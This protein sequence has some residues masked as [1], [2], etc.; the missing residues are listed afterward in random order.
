MSTPDASS[1]ESKSGTAPI[2]WIA[3]ALALACGIALRLAWPLDIEYKTDERWTF[4]QVQALLAGGAWPWIGMRTSFGPPNPGLSLW[5][6]AG[7]GWLFAPQTP[8]QLARL[9]QGLNIAALLAFVAF[10]RFAVPALRR[11]LWLWA[12]ALWAVNPVAIIYERK[13]WP[14]SVLPIFTVALI[15]AWW[16][17]HR[18]VPA[19][20]WGAIGALMTQIH[21]GAGLFAFAL[22]LWTAIT[23]WR[24]A[25]WLAWFTGSALGAVPLLPWLADALTQHR[26]MLVRVRLPIVQFFPRWATQPFGL[27]IHSF[28]GDE[29][30]DFLRSPVFSGTQTYVAGLAYGALA[31]L[32]V[33]MLVRLAAAIGRGG[34]PSARVAFLGDT[35]ELILT[36]S[37]LWGYGGLMTLLTAFG[38]DSS[39]NYLIVIGPVMALWAAILVLEWAVPS[40]PRAGRRLLAGFCLLQA[41][42][43]FGVL[44]YVHNVQIVR[45]DYGPTWLSQQAKP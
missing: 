19:F 18:A 4:E 39:R 6:F 41:A 9:V 7:L 3:L 27:G 38:L 8:P 26:E 31:V 1:A 32:Y 11:E 16:Y 10:A 17:R 22:V 40:D 28:T 37:A 13:I 23:N 44:A 29:F 45:G 30:L 2:I 35:P 36:N 24:S 15:A 21:L 33:W 5:L 20:L 43:S 34:L 12:A 14:P 25:R 42:I